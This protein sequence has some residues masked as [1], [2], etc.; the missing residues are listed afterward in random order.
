M[1]NFQLTQMFVLLSFTTIS[2]QA[3]TAPSDDYQL[4]NT[5]QE[6]YSGN[7]EKA[8]YDLALQKVFAKRNRDLKAKLE[9][10]EP[11][12]SPENKTKYSLAAVSN[13]VTTFMP[14]SPLEWI[15]KNINGQ[16]LSPE[17]LQM[18]KLLAPFFDRVE[19]MRAIFGKN[20]H[21][22]VRTTDFSIIYQHA[23]C[24]AVCDA[25]YAALGAAD[26]ALAAASA[27]A[28][29]ANRDYHAA[30]QLARAKIDSLKQ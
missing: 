16:P 14:L 6:R 21:P 7:G 22:R 10:Q 25:R 29:P 1:K 9:N 2:D 8:F 3:F 15:A 17:A 18:A 11:N 23:A 26:D 4:Y 27:R 19:L 30:N 12:S 13:H 20:V 5:Q 28:N 24:A